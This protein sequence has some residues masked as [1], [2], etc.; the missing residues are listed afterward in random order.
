MALCKGEPVHYKIRENSG[1]T[2]EWICQHVVPKICL[3]YCES[4]SAVLGRAL[5]C[6]IF[7][8]KQ[9]KVV[10]KFIVNCVMAAYRELENN[11]LAVGVNPVKKVPLMVCYL[12][13]L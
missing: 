11:K 6:H 9:K 2:K 7:D 8:E 12:V 13:C 3:K 10:P 4:I 1:I 5:L